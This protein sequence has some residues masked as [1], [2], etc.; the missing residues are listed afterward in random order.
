MNLQLLLTDQV[1]LRR[2]SYTFVGVCVASGALAAFSI[3]STVLST[4]ASTEA[5]TVSKNLE[6]RIAEAQQTISQAKDLKVERKSELPPL[7]RFQSAVE[8][9]AKTSGCEV[10]EFSVT[11]EA[12]PY[13][14]LFGS[15]TKAPDWMQTEVKMS[16]LG[17][18]GSIMASVREMAKTPVPIEFNSIEFTRADVNPKTGESQLRAFIDLRVLTRST[19]GG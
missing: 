1:L 3:G 12:T 13:I 14:S 5:T 8:N 16:L 2:I 11:G 7:N 19:G 6:K 15:E 18:L 9:I 17:S 10:D 4:N